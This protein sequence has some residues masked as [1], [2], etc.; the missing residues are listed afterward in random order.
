MSVCS[1]IVNNGAH[2]N[3]ICILDNFRNKC[4]SGDVGY[5]KE[6]VED[7]SRAMEKA[8]YANYPPNTGVR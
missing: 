3:T 8:R 2:M 5:N 6:E 1:W 4:H 7:T